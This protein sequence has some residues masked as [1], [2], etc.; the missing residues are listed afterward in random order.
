MRPHKLLLPLVA[1]T[2][3][4]A[5]GCAK[6]VPYD[7]PGG[8]PAASMAALGQAIPNDACAPA[9]GAYGSVQGRPNLWT[10][11]DLPAC[12]GSRPGWRCESSCAPYVVQWNP[13]GTDAMRAKVLRAV[14]DVASC[15]GELR[16]YQAAYYGRTGGAP[17]EQ[18]GQAIS[19]STPAR[20]VVEVPVDAAIGNATVEASIKPTAGCELLRLSFCP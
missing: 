16:A 8:A 19:T 7:N 14:L 11:R 1:L 13:A 17:S 20:Y 2:A 3:L 5:A 9:P 15:R 10:Q 4:L 12:G 18:P 6:S